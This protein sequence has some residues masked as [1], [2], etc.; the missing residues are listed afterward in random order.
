VSAIKELAG[1]LS[2]ISEMSQSIS[3]STEEQTTNAHQ[4]S[5]AIEGI[6]EVTQSS[7]S[8]AEQMTASTERL[9]GMAQEL[10]RLV[11]QFKIK[12]EEPDPKAAAAIRAGG[13]AGQ[14]PSLGGP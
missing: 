6:N 11:V 2:T 1:A 5:R 14:L 12:E 9:Q 13:S 8:G 10:Q 3:A 4:M 7:A